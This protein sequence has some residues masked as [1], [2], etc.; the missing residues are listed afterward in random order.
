[1]RDVSIGQL[2]PVDSLVHRLDPRIKLLITIAYIVLLF[3]ANNFVQLGFMAVALLFVIFLSRVPL[4][5][6][7]G[8]LRYIIVLLLFTMLF[9]VLFNK[10]NGADAEIAAGGFYYEWGIFTICSTG[11]YKGGLLMTRLVLLV[12]GPTMLTFTTTPVALTDAIESLLTPLK[13]IKVPVHEFAMI[14][15]IALRLIPTLMEETTKIMNAQKARGACFDHGNIFKR[16]KALI[17]VLIP[18]F[19]SSFKRADELADAMESRC[20]KG[21]K[22]RTKMKV[23]KLHFVDIL[24]AFLMICLFFFILLLVYNWWNWQWVEVLRVA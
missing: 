7:L 4:L 10:G 12:T 3:F 6:V 11:V 18:L 22:G 5:K 19:V 13:W 14:M 8:S 17:P 24:A 1:M 9:T 16:G 23:M 2:Y 21:A 15:S 20:Y